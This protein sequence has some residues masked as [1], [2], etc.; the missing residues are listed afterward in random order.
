MDG[1]LEPHCLYPRYCHTKSFIR[2]Y[3]NCN[4]LRCPVCVQVKIYR[5]QQ[6]NARV[7]ADFKIKSSKVGKARASVHHSDGPGGG[8]THCDDNLKLR[9]DMRTPVFSKLQKQNPC[10]A[11]DASKAAKYLD[12]TRSLDE[13]RMANDTKEDCIINPTSTLE[14]RLSGLTKRRKLNDY[15]QIQQNANSSPPGTIIPPAPEVSSSETTTTM[16][17]K[18]V[19]ENGDQLE[20]EMAEILM[21][22]SVY[23]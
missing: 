10:P 14:S 19:P 4:D 3:E 12:V 2:H 9:E 6:A 11:D 17:I 15:N 8:A 16:E 22:M 23:R 1:C 18:K 13:Y 7:L 20:M 21:S 5:Q